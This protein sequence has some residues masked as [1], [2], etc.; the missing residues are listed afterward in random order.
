MR[1][2][3]SLALQGTATL[4]LIGALSVPAQAQVSVSADTSEQ[5][6]T[7]TAGAGD[8]PS[9]VTIETGVTVTGNTANPAVV[10][11]SDN[12][13]VNDGS[14]VINIE[15]PTDQADGQTPVGV[16]LEGGANRSYTQTGSVTISENFTPEDT[17][18]DPFT[19][20][21][22]ALGA[23]RTGI[24]ISGAS[25]F[26]GNIELTETS[27]L[28][29]EGND[30][31]GI[32][33]ANT[34]MMTE[35]LTG[36]LTTAGN[37]SV[38]GDRSVG[39]NIGSNVTGD[40]INTGGI[41]V[42]G[43]GA[44][45]YVVDA[46]I[47]GGF[48]TAGNLS[49]T[50]FRFNTRPNFGGPDTAVGREDLTAEDLRQAGSAITIAG[51]VSGGIFLQQRS[52]QLFDADGNP[53]LDANEDPVFSIV[54]SSAVSQFGSA[55]AV[56]IGRDGNPIAVGV[57][58]EI[59][60]PTNADFD[61]SLQFAFIN[62]GSVSANGVFDD[63]DTT[64]VSISNATLAGGL[65]NSGTL[66]AS[67]FRAAVETETAIGDGIA[68]VLV[69]GD[70]AI[71]DRINNSRTGVILA[72]VEEATDQIYFDRTNIIA[73]RDLLAV[74][75]DI[76]QGAS[77]SE[78]VNS[79][80]ISAIL[81][82]RDGTAVAVRDASG[83][84]RTLDNN[85]NITALARNSDSTGGE[86]TNF[87]LIA[88]DVSALT[89]GFT[90]T[91]S[92]TDETVNAPFVVGDILLGS[93]DD[94]L[95]VSAGSIAGDIDF[96][97]GNDALSLSGGAAFSGAI[98]N[99]G[100]LNLS[101]T[102]N[103][104]L[105]LA[106]AT[107]IPVSEAR[108]DGTSVFRP[109]VDGQ[110]GLASTLVSDNAITFE[111]GATINPI[112]SS[113][114]NDVRR[115]DI[116]LGDGIQ[117]QRFNIAVA[118]SLTVGDLAGLSG[119]V[120]PFLYNTSLSLADANTLVITL[121]L[122][123]PSQ[124]IEN[125][126]LGLDT[127]Q[128]AAFGEFVDGQFNPG[129]AFQAFANTPELGN[130]FSNITEASEFY[131]AINQILPEFSGAAKQFVL[132]NVD[133]AVGAVGSHLDTT[134]RSP[135]KTGGAW[136]QEFFYFADRSLAGLSEQYRGA[137]F[138]FTGGLDTAFG[139]F[140]AVGLSAGFASTEIEDV[141]GVDNPLNVRTYTLGTYAGFESGGLS[142]DTYG[143]IGLNQFDQD[144]VVQVSNFLGTAQGEWEGLHANASIR[145]GYDIPLSEKYWIRP[146]ASLDYLYLN[147]YG[148]TETGTQG[149]ALRVDGRRSET[150]AATASIDFGAKFQGNRTW[151]RPSF[152]VG[153]RNE[154]IS[155]PVET[156]FRFQGLQ[157]S[158][159]GLFDS[160]LARLRSL[161]FPN[162]G[163]ILGFTVAAGSEFSSV[164][165]DFDS[166][167]RDGF[168]RHTGRIVIRLLF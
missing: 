57:I 36:N 27:T 34:P 95:T 114:I 100:S 85:G 40:L 165:F 5:I 70:N 61:E 106:S 168:V 1:H 65:S 154:F 159:G 74:A 120:S 126:G 26:Q 16:S 55:P 88:I 128:A 141:V 113:I 137:G 21:G 59:T 3:K 156:A 63:F 14:V 162:E 157:G 38:I 153:Y 158:D 37:I 58:A 127:V 32:N 28:L 131:A 139:P 72:Q 160:E 96:G 6:R 84:L 43:E 66:N 121:D 166:D 167:I 109:V 45:G 53:I 31:F 133:G 60:D 142:I 104:S 20:G 71:V 91:Q 17:D 35:G 97:G 149:V 78:L 2:F 105:T 144:R 135:D 64:A 67:S 50:G 18:D 151:I 140:H 148:R 122:R 22:V 152:R 24:L 101:V 73:P 115:E 124:S 49:A 143:G 102:D 42:T 83:T 108:F 15:N 54:S 25:P 163:I 130:A 134:R 62:Q 19:D 79:G 12:A 9:D 80:S 117:S 103:A 33:L 118:D 119:G 7:S 87:N 112:L 51:D 86:E 8:T 90:F 98:A 107:P 29:V 47:Q 94:T 68:R 77:V 123:D 30:S 52:E 161:A 147:E 164:G 76:G 75:I 125:G 4:A 116:G 69:L 82:G 132:A 81:V 150:A 145:A 129:A 93:G 56:I 99:T 92:Q 13:L 41:A 39:V 136:L 46:D 110:T 155:D 11:D 23:N 44:R 89:E 48:V 146:R 138:G 111:A 10:L